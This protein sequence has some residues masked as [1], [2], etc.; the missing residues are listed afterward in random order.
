MRITKDEEYNLLYIYFKDKLGDGEV[1]T[2][3]EFLPGAYM[4]LDADGRLLGIEIVNTKSDLGIPAAE[5]RLP[6]E[7]VK[8]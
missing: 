4:D 3:R 6:G 2:T 7:T 1:A 5:L 8:P